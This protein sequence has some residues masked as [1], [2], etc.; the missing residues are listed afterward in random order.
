MAAVCL[1]LSGCSVLPGPASGQKHMTAYF[2][3]T[4]SFYAHS[5][6]V[7]MG[8]SVGKV[9]R[10]TIQGDRIK[11]DFHVNADV[12]VVRGV[13]AAIVPLNLVGE[14]NLVLTPVWKPGEPQA[15]DGTVIPESRTRVPVETDQALRAFTN[16]A[17]ALDPRKVRAALGKAASSFA[18]NGDAFNLALQQ[19]GTLTDSVAGQTGNLLA[20][21]RNLNSLAGVVRGREQVIGT[22]IQD[23]G[24]ASSV[25]AQEKTDIQGLVGNVLALV[26]SGKTLLDKYQGNLP[27]DLAVLTRVAL[28]L[29]GDQSQ[30]TTLVKVLPD[31]AA[32]FIDGYDRRQNALVLRFATDAFL[33][34]WIKALTRNDGTPCPLPAPNS[35]CP[36]MPDQKGAK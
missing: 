30:V 3:T 4:N 23:F 34:T 22:L 26:N 16:V 7:L 20:V 21:A 17:D 36:W 14:R 35:N 1:A 5:N 31:I 32:E 11:V 15:G 10:I 33:R 19:T 24:T 27:G 25:L 8:V 9:D 28:T 18:G 12:P 2:S 6:V 29:Q 13:N